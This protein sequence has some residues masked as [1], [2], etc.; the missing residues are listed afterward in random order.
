MVKKLSFI[1][2]KIFFYLDLLFYKITK[3]SILI[4]FKEFIQ[5]DSY[6]TINVL[7]KKVNFFVPNQITQWRVKT[8][9]T[10]EPETLEWIDSF[11]DSKK[12]IFWDIGANIG[13]YSIYAALKY[14]DIEIISFEPS[15]SNLRVLSRKYFQLI[16]L[17][18]KIEI[19]Q[20]PLTKDESQHLM[21]EEK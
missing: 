16:N 9:L 18:K 3:R 13:L 17:K 15:T 11:D 19:Y 14:P 12:I 7:N 10:K 1:I 20:L 5:N 8:F 2:Y 6:K 4:W 21:F